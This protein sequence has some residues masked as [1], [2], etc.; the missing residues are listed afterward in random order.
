MA[1]TK[2][3]YN[4]A[5]AAQVSGVSVATL[6][7]AIRS[8]DLAAFQPQIEGRQIQLQLIRAEELERWITSS[9]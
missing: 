7:K 9:K 6:R 3:T 4:V 1:E 2:L 5:E 8:G